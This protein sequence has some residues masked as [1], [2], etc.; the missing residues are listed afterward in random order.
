MHEVWRQAWREQ[1]M[2]AGIGRLCRAA[3]GCGVVVTG[4]A[5]GGCVFT[6][7]EREQAYAARVPM[8]ESHAGDGSERIAVWPL[9][10]N[11]RAA[12]GSRVGRMTADAGGIGGE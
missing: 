7:G 10:V 1:A 4:M 3:G 12:R 11:T 2:D 8:S 9:L 6:P 5:M